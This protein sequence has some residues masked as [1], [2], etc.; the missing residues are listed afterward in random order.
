MGWRLWHWWSI[1]TG[2]WTRKHYIGNGDHGLETVALVEY[3]HGNLDTQT[4]HWQWGSWAGDCGTGGVLPREPGHANITLAMG[5]MGWRLWHWWSIATGTWTRKH[6]IGNGD[7]GLETVALVEYCHGNLDTQTLHW[8]WGS[9]AGDCGTGGVLPREP[10]HA[11]ITLAMGIMGWRLWHWWSIATGTWTRKH[12]IGNGD[13]GLETVA[14]VEYCHGNLDTQTLHW[15]WGSWAGDC[16]TGGVLPREPRHANITLAMGIMGWR[17]WHWWSIATGT[18]TRKHYIGNGDHG[19]ETVAL[20]E[21]CHGNLD[22]QTLHWQWGS[23]AGDCGTGGVLPREPGHANITLATGI[24]I[25]IT[26]NMQHGIGILLWKEKCYILSLLMFIF[27]EAGFQMPN[28]IAT[29][30]SSQ[31]GYVLKSWQS[32][33]T[34]QAVWGS[35]R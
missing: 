31:P 14:L 18:W 7:H 8:Q 17:L 15:Q 19:L 23:W 34:Q 4:L 21:Y 5:I 32:A 27:K 16:G 35:M 6:Y 12:Y 2:T 20:V 22:T 29:V 25:S 3:C 26:A 28:T 1:A 10:G 30:F 11:N 24:R 33:F 9:W 13:H